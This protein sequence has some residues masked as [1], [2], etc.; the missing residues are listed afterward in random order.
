MC[1]HYW[2]A[3]TT[4]RDKFG[5]GVE[6]PI[7]RASGTGE[8]GIVDSLACCSAHIWFRIWCA[9]DFILTIPRD[10]DKLHR[11][12][13]G[14]VHSFLLGLNGHRVIRT[15][16]ESHY[17]TNAPLLFADLDDPP[18][19]EALRWHLPATENDR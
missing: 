1:E 4:R 3:Q 13:P 11:N 6:S 17:H 16:P 2:Q 12:D 8:A 15:R 5:Q 18:S 9:R 10:G 19:R 7:Y 14:S